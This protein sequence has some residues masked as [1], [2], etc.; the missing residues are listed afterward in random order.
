M[1]HGGADTRDYFRVYLLGVRGAVRLIYYPF[2]PPWVD[3]NA[4][5]DQWLNFLLNTLKGLYKARL[6]GL[7][8]QHH[9][10]L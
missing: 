7:V 2:P 9:T 3:K 6:Y 4:F 8:S 5:E 10:A 1:S